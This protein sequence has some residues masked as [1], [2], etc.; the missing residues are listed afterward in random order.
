M[1]TIK[2]VGMTLTKA[3]PQ[4]FHIMWKVSTAFQGLEWADTRLRERRLKM[5]LVGRL[6]QLGTGGF[7]RIVMGC[8]MLIGKVCDPAVDHYALKPV[9]RGAPELL[10]AAKRLE[11]RGFFNPVSCADDATLKD[12]KRM[13]EALMAAAGG[14][15]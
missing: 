10:A 3:S 8:E 5:V 1:T 9:Y 14:V 11:A 7:M 4:D 2:T 13:R 15:V 6:D 12:M